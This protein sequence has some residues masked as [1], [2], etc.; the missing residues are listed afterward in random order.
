MTPFG[1]VGEDGEGVRVESHLGLV[2]LMCLVKP[3]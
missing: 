1:E 2:K 3:I